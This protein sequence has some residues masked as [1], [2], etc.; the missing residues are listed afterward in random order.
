M[1]GNRCRGK[2]FED[3]ASLLAESPDAPVPI[4]DADEEQSGSPAWGR[5][6]RA[7]CW[8][9]VKATLCSNNTLAIVDQSIVSCTRFLTSIIVGRVCGPHVLGDYT[10]GFT[11]YCLAAC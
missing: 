10:L 4:N 2:Q 1:D 6:S 11:I 9:Y 7:D 8:T 3:P 5:A